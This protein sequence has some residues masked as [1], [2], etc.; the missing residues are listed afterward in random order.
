MKLLITGFDAFGKDRINPSFKAVSMLPDNI[1]DLKIFKRELPTKYKESELVLN[2][3]INEIDPDYIIAVGQAEGRS[4]I[5]L[6]KV[7]I[8]LMNARIADN[9]GYQPIDESIKIGGKTAYFS[10]LPLSKLFSNLEDHK[11]PVEISYSAGAFVCNKVF[12]DLM[13]SINEKG[14]K[15]KAGFVH[16]PLIPAQLENR[17]QHIPTMELSEIVKSLTIVI[18][19]LSEL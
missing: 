18:T 8:N 15:F 10:N 14:S 2:K 3:Y 5:S 13:Y 16:I 9:D 12:Y 1:N 4:N 19:S 17:E 7:A 6:E 11:I